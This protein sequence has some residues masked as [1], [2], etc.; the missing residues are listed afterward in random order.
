MHPDDAEDLCRYQMKFIAPNA[1]KIATEKAIA[2][3]ITDNEILSL[4]ETKKKIDYEDYDEEIE[5][6]EKWM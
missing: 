6:E 1:M 2:D 5:E 4:E 3:R